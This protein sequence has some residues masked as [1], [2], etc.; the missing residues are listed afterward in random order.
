MMRSFLVFLET[1]T[2]PTKP[3]PKFR[4]N[5]GDGEVGLVVKA[6]SSEGAK[7]SVERRAMKAAQYSRMTMS[8]DVAGFLP[9][10]QSCAFNV[11]YPVPQSLH[12]GLNSHAL[13]RKA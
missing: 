13:F 12:P 8:R 5:P 6:C 9:L 3:S 7:E 10:L 1:P 11:E 2:C 4:K